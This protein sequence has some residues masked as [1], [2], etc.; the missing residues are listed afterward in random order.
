M[1]GK[2]ITVMLFASLLLSTAAFAQKDVFYGGNIGFNVSSD[3]WMINLSPLAG[4][5]FT[6]SF[7]GGLGLIYQYYRYKTEPRL[8]IN[9]YG[10]APFLRYDLSATLMKDM[11]FGIFFQTDYEGTRNSYR[12]DSNIYGN[13]SEFVNRL[14]LGAGYI[15]PLTERTRIFLMISFDMLH[16]NGKSGTVPVVR[17]GIIF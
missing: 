17:G 16:L 12:Y 1:K 3:Y 9:S 13:Y 5:N 4:Y 11:P 7:A 2:H 10:I 14:Y 15:Q 6:P 8:S